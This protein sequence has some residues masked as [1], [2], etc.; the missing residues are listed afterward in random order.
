MKYSISYVA[1]KHETRELMTLTG[2]CKM[3]ISSMIKI[4]CSVIIHQYTYTRV[5]LNNT[6]WWQGKEYRAVM[7]CTQECNCGS[8][9]P[10]HVC[11]M[12]INNCVCV[13]LCLVTFLM[14][15]ITC[16][17]SIGENVKLLVDRPDGNFCFRLHKDKVYYVK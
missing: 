1:V 14:F 11:M 3:F 12:E 15:F 5:T 16:I 17:Y 9:S 7:T 13:F 4:K 10:H 2:G 6:T 8:V